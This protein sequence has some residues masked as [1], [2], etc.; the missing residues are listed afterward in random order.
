MFIF[1]IGEIKEQWKKYLLIGLLVLCVMAVILIVLY[2]NGTKMPQSA[3]C[4]QLGE[5]SLQVQDSTKQI[6][7]LSQFGL[8]TDEAS[9]VSDEV[10]IPANFNEGYTKYNE[11][12]KKIGLDLSN[13]KGVTAKRNIY[14]LNNYEKDGKDYYVT[15]LIYKECVIGGHIGTKEYGVDYKPLI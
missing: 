2:I 1:A 4:D 12:Q 3:T 7:F 11:L 10:V 15:L 8:E 5:Y 9:L 6:E 13:Y 14:K